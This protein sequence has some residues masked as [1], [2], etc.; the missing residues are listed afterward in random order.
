MRILPLAG[1]QTQSQNNKKQNMNFGIAKVID[2]PPKVLKRFD[3]IPL[4]EICEKIRT[5]DLCKIGFPELTEIQKER[6]QRIEDV[7]ADHGMT[8]GES[9][10]LNELFTG[11]KFDPILDYIEGKLKHPVPF[12]N[13]EAQETLD[14][15][16]ELGTKIGRAEDIL[17]KF[18][19]RLGTLW[20]DFDKKFGN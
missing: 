20:E 2:V 15:A 10:E 9:D 19:S 18:Q 12:T 1:Y 5:P 17:Q 13:K 7:A 11:N 14:K 16:D 6:L 8:I 3:F 4:N